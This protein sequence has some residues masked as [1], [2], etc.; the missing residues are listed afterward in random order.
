MA[1][2]PQEV[3]TRLKAI[4]PD[5][6]FIRY[7]IRRIQG[8]K[9]R[10]IHA[11]QHNRLTR[12][13]VWQILDAIFRV[14]GTGK[15]LIPPGDYSRDKSVE[16]GYEEFV[17]IVSRIKKTSGHGTAN[18]I[19][20]TFF[21]DLAKMGFIIREKLPKGLSGQLSAEGLAYRKTESDRDR[22]V[23]YAS[24][25]ERLA[26]ALMRIIEIWRESK[27]GKETLQFND[28]MLI[29]TD[30]ELQSETLSVLDAYRRLG[31]MRQD[32][33]VKLVRQYAN[34]KNFPT[35]LKKRDY[36]NWSN[37]TEQ[38]LS[39]LAEGGF[40]IKTDNGYRLASERSSADT[41]RSGEGESDKPFET[42]SAPSAPLPK[43]RG[44]I[45]RY[46]PNRPA[47]TYLLR[48]ANSDIWKVGW[49]HNVAAR[50][51]DINTHIPTEL[52]RR[53]PELDD[54]PQWHIHKSHEWT[55]A[56]QAHA[57]EQAVLRALAE[58]RL[59]TRHERAEA[60]ESVILAIW[61][62]AMR[63]QLN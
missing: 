23:L 63:R 17:D 62:Q 21:P 11:S 20:K 7:I 40:I 8:E 52:L 48:F 36:G 4:A 47:S 18:S 46:D 56:Q 27:Y 22:Q 49:A 15:F 55:N 19:K 33:V 13:R 39:L 14:V 32:E 1:S 3:L 9:Y 12:E 26:P 2:D 61:Q 31:S 60:K 10:G 58:R 37:A 59:T 42:H 6:E 29:L 16:P 30:A 34:P 41:M 53:L 57:V 50:C 25:V 54:N 43:E 24:G 28:F 45:A 5:N 51:R 35:K 38:A 44:Y